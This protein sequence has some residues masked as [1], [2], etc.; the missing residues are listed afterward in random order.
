MFEKDGTVYEDEGDYLETL[1]LD[2]SYHFSYP[3]EY[4]VERIGDDDYETDTTTMEVD[5][6][7][8]YEEH[9]YKVNYNL[10][11]SNKVPIEYNGD[12]DA[13]FTDIIYFKVVDDLYSLGISNETFAFG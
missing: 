8:D 13:I 1:K 12:E 3:F 2:D 7:W 9:G 11:D 10:I 5:V 4:I 6:Y